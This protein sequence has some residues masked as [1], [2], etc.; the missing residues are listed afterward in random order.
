MKADGV[1]WYELGTS[2]FMDAADSTEIGPIYDG[3]DLHPE[4]E[5]RILP[6]VSDAPLE[7]VIQLLHDGGLMVFLRPGIEINEPGVWRGWIEPADWDLWF[8]SYSGF[9]SHYAALAERTEV[10]LFSVGFE[11]NS[12]VDQTQGWQSVI[13]SVRDAYSGPIT[14]DAGGVL[15]D[16]DESAYTTDI[17]SSEWESAS[18]GAFAANVDY[19][20]IDWYPQIAAESDSTTEEMALNAQ[21]IADEFLVPLVEEYGKPLLFAEIDYS[22]VDRTA[23]NPLRYR[24][25]GPIDEGEQAAAFE[26]IFRTFGDEPWFAGMFPAGFYLGV[27]EDEV[28]TTNSLWYKEAEDVFRHWYGGPRPKTPTPS[29]TPTPSATPTSTR[30]P[31][32]TPTPSPTR[33]PR[34]T[35]TPTLPPLRMG[36]ANCDSTVN[37][38]DAAWV[39]QLSA[40][41]ILSLPCHEAADVNSSGFI[42]AIDA[43]LIL[44]FTAGLLP[45]L[46]V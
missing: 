21:R 28:G 10:E 18:I 5:H 33:T 42:D 41:L 1:N 4:L 17:F 3:A 27:F 40:G 15:Y 16:G 30:T 23:V 35:P 45:T 24:G 14:Y 31:V 38:I 37:S 20:G 44:Q 9:M 12:S 34:V 46:P 19:I 29:P 11:L 36:D 13:S 43:A 8:A 6:T 39:L 25:D 32:A 26:A 22:S 2:W 7:E